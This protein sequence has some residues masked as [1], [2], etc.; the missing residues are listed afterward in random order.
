MASLPPDHDALIADDIGR[1]RLQAHRYGTVWAAVASVVTA[2]LFIWAQGQL[3]SLGRSGVWLIA[4]GLA[5]G[6]RLVVLAGHQRAE[7]ADQD[8]RRWLWRYRVAIGLHGLVWGASAWLPSSLADPEQQDVLLLMLTGLA[9]GAMTLTLFDLRAALLFAL[10]CTVPLT[11]RLLF[12]AAPL[13]VATVVAM[14]MAVLLMG[15]LTVA[16]RRASRERRALAITLRAEDDNARGAREAEAMLRMLFEHVGQGI[17]V[18]DKDLRLRAWN[19][20]SAKF[21]GADPGIVRAGLPLR[22]VLLTMR[23]AGQF[24]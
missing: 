10:P 18:F 15:M 7:Q 2:A 22:T 6:M 24:G 19:A 9:V 1:S 17:S 12:G 13:A 5:I 4:L 8:W 3:S 11:L 21:I 14:L 16:A 23:R 20:E